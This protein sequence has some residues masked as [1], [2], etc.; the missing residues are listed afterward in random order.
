MQRANAIERVLF[1]LLLFA[2]GGAGF[3]YEIYNDEIRGVI[4]VPMIVAYILVSYLAYKALLKFAL[5]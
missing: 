1:V 2:L 5:R 4:L 3:L